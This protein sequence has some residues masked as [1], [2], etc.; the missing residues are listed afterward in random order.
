MSKIKVIFWEIFLILTINILLLNKN[1][2]ILRLFIYLLIVLLFS[3]SFGL[4]QIE[5]FLPTSHFH[6]RE[7]TNMSMGNFITTDHLTTVDISDI[8]I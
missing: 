4:G 7:Q 3:I 8:S 6:D 5:K 2:K 1:S